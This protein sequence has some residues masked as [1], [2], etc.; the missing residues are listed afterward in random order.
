MTN[1][2]ST[3]RR[4]V[5]LQPPSAFTLLELLVSVAVL[6]ILIL[7]LAQVSNMVANTW[8][9]GN[10][11]A[12]RRANGRALVDFMARELRSAALPVAQP[13]DSDGEVITTYPDL[14][15]VHNPSTV[16]EKF[17]HPHAVFWQAP[18]A[19]NLTEG[20]LATIGY[21]IRWDTTTSN[22][23]RAMLCRYF[24]NPNDDA[25][26]IY[27]NPEVWIDDNAIEKVAPGDNRLDSA[28]QLNA[29]RGLF[30]DNVIAFWAQCYDAAG[31]IIDGT[32]SNQGNL[33]TNSFDSRKDYT[34][35]DAQ[36]E[37]RTFTAPTLP[38]SVDVSFVLVDSRTASLFTVNTMNKLIAL[39][40]D[41]R[42]NSAATY[43]DVLRADQSLKQ[44]AQGATAHHLRIYLD[45]AP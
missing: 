20:D 37:S 44:V 26:D 1:S 43:V 5:H 6:S 42:C 3:S 2:S 11:R 23:P 30:A 19:N 9:N 13:R 15:F 16:S 7:M 41:T 31:N 40:R 12:E 27:K 14:N 17:L 32:S 38:H 35:K 21:F 10:A 29:Y 39:A 4:L 28:G 24:V 18:I 25:Y 33:S 45:N 8:N 22:I 36:G 34:G